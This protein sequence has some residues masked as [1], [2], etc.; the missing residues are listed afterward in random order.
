MG[1]L[2]VLPV[3]FVG[4]LGIVTMVVTWLRREKDALHVGLGLSGLSLLIFGLLWLIVGC[5]LPSPLPLPKPL[6]PRAAM[7]QVAR[8]PDATYQ[9]SVKA[10]SAL[11][12]VARLQTDPQ[13][14]VVS[15]QWHN[16]VD[17][18]VR[19]EADTQGSVVPINGAV[20]PNKLTV[21]EFTEVEDLAGVLKEKC[22]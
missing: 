1:T 12:Q 3:V 17:M 6:A 9:C 14:R 2:V 20:A 7:V 10:I 16:A 22:S 5:A 11:G 21:G 4:V 8:A 19:V 15:F 13:S 18:V